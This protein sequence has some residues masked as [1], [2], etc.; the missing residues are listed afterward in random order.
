MKFLSVFVV[1]VCLGLALGDAGGFD[2]S[3]KNPIAMS[4]VSE[5]TVPMIDLPVVVNE[6]VPEEIPDV[7][8]SKESIVSSVPVVASG[9]K[10]KNKRTVLAKVTSYC[11]CKICCGSDANGITST[12]K[13]ARGRGIAADPRAIK[14]GTKLH[15]PGY[16]VAV[17][18]DTGGAMRQS[19][20]RGKYH[21]DIRKKT[22]SEALSW[23][24]KWLVVTLEE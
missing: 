23:G 6:D 2:C 4:S 18:D 13:S 14:Y 22:H 20:R 17:V 10:K 19:W 1:V 21:F 15:I 12:G 7:I 24:E 8:E 16:G 5:L 3:T 11:P 9:S